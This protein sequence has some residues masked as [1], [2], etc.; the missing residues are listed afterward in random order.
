MALL[1]LL[2]PSKPQECLCL[3]DPALLELHEG[4]GIANEFVGPAPEHAS[5][6][7]LV[8]GGQREAEYL[9]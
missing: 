2:L 3:M 4:G 6:K 1:V 7:I 5:D 8:F 9:W